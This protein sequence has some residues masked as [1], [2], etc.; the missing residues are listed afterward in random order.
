MTNDNTS[1]APDLEAILNAAGTMMI[2]CDRD[3]TVRVFNP[4][5]E[6]LL[7][8]SA[9]EIVGRHTVAKWH[10]RDEIIRRAAELTIELGRDIS[11]DFQ[12]FVVLAEESG[13]PE[14]RAWTYIRKDG[15]RFPVELVVSAIRDAAGVVTGYL[16]TALDISQRVHA[17]QERDLLFN[18]SLDIQCVAS[19]DGY[20]K[21]V[22]P[23]F[24]RILG[25]SEAELLLRPFL[26]MVHPDDRE[27]TQQEVDKQTAGQPTLTFENRYL[28]RDGS[29]RL[30][31]WTS[32]PQPDGRMFATA[33]DVTEL[34]RAEEELRASQQDLAI[35]LRSIGDGVIATDAERRITRMNPVAE[36]LTGWR[37][38]DAVGRPIKEVF[39]IE[40]EVTRQPAVIP[41]DA[42]LATGTVQGLANHTVLI[43]RDGRELPIADSAAPIRNIAGS[44]SGVVLVFRDA[45][46]E[47]KFERELQELNAS[48]ER[49]VAL[50]TEQLAKEQRWLRNGHLVLES[51]A[52]EAAFPETLELIVRF[53]AEECA[54]A[55]CGILVFDDEGDRPRLGAQRNLPEDFDVS[56]LR[57]PHGESAD[58]IW[59]GVLSGER[60][61]VENLNWTDFGIGG[62]WRSGWVEPIV[63][64]D[65]RVLG[66]IVT[67]RKQSGPPSEDETTCVECAGGLARVALQRAHA[68]AALETAETK[69]RMLL[70]RI[71][72]PV[73]V[74]DRESLEYLV[75]S[76]RAVAEYGYSREEFI[77]MTIAD[78]RPED[79]VAALRNML[80]ESGTAFEHRGLWRHRKKNGRLIDVEITTRGLELAGRPACIVLA[81]DVTEK[82]RAEN[83]LRRSEAINQ[84][85]L[86]SSLDSIVTMN[87]AGE[88]VEFNRAA[89]QTFGYSSAQAMGRPVK[90]LLIPPELREEHEQGLA[91]YLKTDEQHILCKRIQTTAL[92]SDGQ[93][94]PV[95]LTVVPVIVDGERLFTAFLRD[96]TVAQ[97]AERELHRTT[98]LLQAIV[99]ETTDAIFVKDIQGRYLLFNRAAAELTGRPVDEVLG[100]D[101]IFVFGPEHGRTVMENDQLVMQSNQPHIVEEELAAAGTTRSYHCMKAPL[102][103]PN[104]NVVGMI[105]ISRD[106]TERRE[107]ESAL[108]A[109][110]ERYRSIIEQSPD[111]IFVNRDD[112]ISFINQAGVDLLGASSAEELLGRSPLQHVH[113]DDHAL[114]QQR[115]A[116]LRKGPGTVPIVEQRLIAL[117]GRIIDVDVQAASYY[118]DGKLE[119][120]VVCRD[121]TARK[122]A[123]QELRRHVR[124]ANFSAAVGLA[125]SHSP[126]L[127][128][129]L[130]SCTEAMVEHLDA[131]FARV[132]TFNE[133]EGVL[134]LQASAGAYTRL[135]G[136][137]ARVPVGQKKIGMIAATKLP[138]LTNSV[139]DDSQIGDPE[140]AR[141]QGF[142]SFAGYPLLIEDRCVGVVAMFGRKAIEQDTLETLAMAANGIAQNI[143]RKQAEA[144]LAEL[145]TTLEQRVVERTLELEASEQF[146]RATLDALSAHVAVVDRDGNIVATN[147]A[148][149]KFAVENGT[150]FQPV[151]EGAN[152]LAICDAAGERGDEDATIVANALRDVLSGRRSAWSHEYPCHSPT[153]PR[154][155]ICQVTLGYINQQPHAVVAHENITSVKLAQEELREAK[156]RAVLASQSKSEFLATMS[157]ELRT[158]LNGILGMNEL[159]L[160]TELSERQREYVAA[161]SSSGQLLV[162]LIN[163][164]LD[165]SKI[166]AGKLELAPR[167]CSLEAFTYNVVDMMSHAARTKQLVL[168]CRVTPDACVTGVFDDTRLRQVL[169]N[170]LSNAVKFTSSGSITVVVDRIAKGDRTTRLRFAVSDTGIGIPQE[171]LDRLFKSFSQV[172]SST[173][174]QFGGTGL[175]LSICRQLIELMGGEIGVESQVGVGTTFWF[176]IE[177]VTSGVESSSEQG[178][179]LLAGTEFIVIDGPAQGRVEVAECLRSWGCP[180][181]Q[182]AT[183][184]DAKT[185]V[186]N[187]LGAGRPVRIVLADLRLE[188]GSKLSQLTELAALP[189]VHVIGLGAPPDEVSRNRL[190][191]L[192]FRHVLADPIRPSVLFD[193]LTEVLSVRIEPATTTTDH[194][195]LSRKPSAK[196]SSHILVAEDNPINQLYIIELLKHFGCTSDLASNGEEALA[197]VQQQRY[198]LV[199]MDCQMPEMDGFT[200]AREIRRKE[201]SGELPRRHYIV[202]LT[203][204]ALA[205]DRERCMEAGMDDYLAKPLQPEKLHEVLQKHS[206]SGEAE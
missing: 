77:Q 113:T 205:G 75:V 13:S 194:A 11:A 12:V 174:R 46:Q 72:A 57:P 6:R 40:H 8:W 153:G 102:R 22:N 104:G 168:N 25:W 121:V 80:S 83:S 182:V 26:D 24:T 78:I 179:Q 87:D 60:V 137:H 150:D 123:E 160:T 116:R 144:A 16:G 170:L 89:E 167:E 165:L 2:A 81:Q 173:T 36:Q 203:A 141:D 184:H 151:S 98:G 28:C 93:T 130:K 129:M 19:N 126:T 138:H 29:W 32:A 172:D 64:G 76:D 192:G 169:V 133:Q 101:D 67:F 131:A 59:Q 84:A 181:Q 114:I 118:S 122:K 50:R 63:T 142:M 100:K 79:D 108:R 178:K 159:L 136:T 189:N 52:S 106:I 180:F 86:Q 70:E 30:L 109:S 154:W 156:E 145:N 34:R 61:K 48:L 115:I 3:G 20:F 112:R 176:E 157:H 110:E 55:A 149:R 74:Y 49:R 120:Q 202:A 18:L 163:D 38:D 17:E 197:A 140:W 177:I 193:T 185:E 68:R 71:P 146:N 124:H 14:Q 5:A 54:A 191:G 53:V 175:G 69:Y 135:D 58:R 155:Y 171:R 21:R 4:A 88:I 147:A 158:P 47:R 125:L 164:I 62:N 201:A 99:D 56:I 196:L 105:G 85:I 117:N 190:H 92:R 96:L 91:R 195:V 31:S 127:P 162:Q 95:E 41:V 15:S 198:D 200:A 188:S 45:S 42:V 39:V 1:P 139:Y 44:I 90:E 33:R 111:M 10:D 161:G 35:T 183:V 152:Y 94:F 23:A 97:R 187:A 9:A 27:T 186:R 148:W 66:G 43:A 82:L 51:I 132:W 199:L 143:E 119:I 166:E 204:N 7:G 103:D 65:G 134:E 128:E 73:F 206:P 107:M 37:E